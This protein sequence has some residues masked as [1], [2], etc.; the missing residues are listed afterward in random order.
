MHRFEREL[1]EHP[2][3]KKVRLH[4]G[5]RFFVRDLEFSVLCTH[6]DIYPNPLSNF[7]DSSTAIMMTAGGCKVLFPGDCAAESDKVFLRR[8]HD[9][10]KCSV[11]RCRITVTRAPRANSTAVR[12]R[13]AF[14][15]R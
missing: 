1:D 15:S 8:Y 9:A 3:I 4:T 7:N 2:E 11:V 14:S 12:A 5:Q 10:L 6:E 13:N